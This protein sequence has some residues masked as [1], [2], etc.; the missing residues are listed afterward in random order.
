[1]NQ[2]EIFRAGKRPDANGQM[3]EI[4]PSDLLQAVN[5]YD[6]NL[7]E[8]PAVIG[9]PQH[10]A[11]AY[12]WVKRLTTTGDILKAELAQVDPNFAEMVDTG[13]F[14][15]VSAS[16]YLADSPHNPK[17]GFLYLRHVGFLGAIPPAVKGLRNP[18]FSEDEKG[19]VNFSIEMEDNAEIN[20]LRAENEQLK[21]EE[22]TRK[23]LE[24]AEGLVSV[25]RLAPIAKAKALEILNYAEECD[26]AGIINFNEGESMAQK[27]REFL[28][29]QPKVVSFGEFATKER[30]VSGQS[31]DVVEYAE[32]TP[33][34]VIELDQQI[35]HCMKQ[36]NVDYSTAFNLIHKSK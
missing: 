24:F 6:P 18:E 20:A 21:A 1:M 13:R 10:N 34:T 30:A 31:S 12:A 27:V 33:A 22:R 28:A 2:I 3:I 9:H 16:F 5:A 8:A 26:Q 36:H 7:H 25:G 17:P 14:K 35:R 19:V 29:L 4:K 11:P 32:N 15:K 23:N